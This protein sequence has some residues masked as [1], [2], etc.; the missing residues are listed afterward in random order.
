MMGQ[1]FTRGILAL[2]FAFVVACTVSCA[3]PAGR[4]SGAVV[5]DATITAQVKSGLLAD[6]DVSGV[7]VSVETFNGE[8]TLTGAVPT[9]AHV[10]KAESIARSVRGVTKVDNLIRIK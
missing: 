4:T 7:A 8:V 2:L 6:K 1:K 9:Q 10:I 3:T 5:D